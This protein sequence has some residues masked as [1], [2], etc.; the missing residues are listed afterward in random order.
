SELDWELLQYD[1][2][3]LLKDCVADLNALLRSEP[4][5]H[6]NQF[7]IYGFEWVDLSHRDEAVMVYR[8]KGKKPAD[9]LL[10]ILN[11]KPVVHNDWEIYVN[12]K[13]FQREIFNSNDKKYWGTGDVFNPEIRGELV[14][15]KEKRYK[16][17]VNLPPLSGIILK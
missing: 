1:G 9:D 17:I 14:D 10:I 5:M 2:H 15:K 16:L 13:V 7:N 11:M 12:D 8:R 6:Q 3:K 4:A